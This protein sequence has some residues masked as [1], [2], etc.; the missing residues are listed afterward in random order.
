MKKPSSGKSSG[1]DGIP[2]ELVKATGPHGV[3]MLHRLCIS[4]WETC[5]WPED[6]K[7]Q[8]FVV[9]IKSD[10][11]K[12]CS[13]YRTIALISHTSKMLLLITVDRLERKLE[14]EQPEEKS[15]YRKGEEP[16]ACLSV[17]KY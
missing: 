12:L 6:W 9:L 2:S 14:S 16:E 15:A 13:G 1:V 3:K 8:E 10:D 7:I 5:H 17:C 11:P 4:I